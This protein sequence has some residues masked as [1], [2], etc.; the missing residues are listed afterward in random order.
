MDLLTEEFARKFLKY[1]PEDYGEPEVTED[2][3]QVFE[4]FGI[5]EEKKVEKTNNSNP[6]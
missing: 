3:Q 4:E 1:D 2:V 6:K 5:A